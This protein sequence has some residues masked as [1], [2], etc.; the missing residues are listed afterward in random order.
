[1]FGKIILHGESCACVTLQL[2]DINNLQR[3]SLLQGGVSQ[4]REIPAEWI[5]AACLEASFSLC[6]AGINGGKST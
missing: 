5:S 1:L 6:Y 4:G 3:N 2:M